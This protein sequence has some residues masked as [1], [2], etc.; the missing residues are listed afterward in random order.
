MPNADMIA[1][2]KLATKRKCPKKRSL[3]PPM[4]LNLVA[5]AALLAIASVTHKIIQIVVTVPTKIVISANL[6]YKN[7]GTV[8]MKPHNPFFLSIRKID[9]LLVGE[10]RNH[11]ITDTIKMIN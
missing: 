2:P 3:M 4:Y 10:T 9:L 7:K 8:Q 5:I 1:N 11:L 6:E